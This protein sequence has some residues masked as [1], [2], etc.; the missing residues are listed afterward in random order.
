MSG[1][2]VSKKFSAAAELIVVLSIRLC[3]WDVDVQGLS[4]DFLELCLIQKTYSVF[5]FM[6]KYKVRTSVGFNNILFVSEKFV[7]KN[8]W[9]VQQH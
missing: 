1:H 9:V 8:I 6:N 5:I 7:G 4:F 2:L 3:V